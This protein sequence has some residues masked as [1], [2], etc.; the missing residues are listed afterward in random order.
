MLYIEVV[1]CI[2]VGSLG[3][4]CLREQGIQTARVPQSKRLPLIRASSAQEPF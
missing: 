4:S 1:L 2:L 3:P